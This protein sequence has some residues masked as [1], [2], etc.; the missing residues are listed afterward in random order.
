VL[1]FFK[2]YDE[3]KEPQI[4]KLKK[5]IEMLKKTNSKVQ[6]SRSQEVSNK[7]EIENLFLDCVDEHKREIIKQKSD[8]NAPIE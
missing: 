4:Q 6:T 8:V 7:G 1:Q 5:R 3:T 2:D